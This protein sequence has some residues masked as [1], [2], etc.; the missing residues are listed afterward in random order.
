MPAFF[1]RMQ[2]IGS[3]NE[4]NV[5][6][7][8]RTHP[9][10]AERIADV[11]NRAQAVGYRQHVDPLVFHLVRAKLR[12]TI[13][14]TVDSRNEAVA[15]FRDQLAKRTYAN[16]AA[17]HY[18][19]AVALLQTRD[20]A[21]AQTELEQAQ[22]LVSHPMLDSLGAALILARGDAP[23]AVA[24]LRAAVAKN[25]R[26]RY[27]QLELI[28]A[29]QHASQHKEA[30]RLLADQAQ[31]YPSDP[32]VYEMQVK[33]Y[34]I[35]G[36]RSLLYQAQA[37]ND[38]LLGRLQPAIDKLLT[39]RCAGGDFYQQSIID[40]RINALYDQL[41]D[42]KRFENGDKEKDKDGPPRTRPPIG[43]PDTRCS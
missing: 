35:I 19:Y 32:K 27:L 10:T 43:K 17:T 39:A 34:N 21:A 13:G 11:R 28:D 1:E 16:L 25:P 23:G 14:S 24:A 4:S 38:A 15:Y 3:V 9:L 31:L 12:A 8:V 40:A 20:Y 36:P 42:Q 18:G 33:S 30:L 7:Y 26:V 37:E 41:A 6:V 22:K 5:P 2:R 29:L